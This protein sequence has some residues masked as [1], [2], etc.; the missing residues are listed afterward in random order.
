[1]WAMGTPIKAP[2]GED[3]RPIPRSLPYEERMTRP[4][5]LGDDVWWGYSVLWLLRPADAHALG[6]FWRGDR[7]VFAGWYGDLQ[8]PLV[9]TAIGFDTSDHVLDVDIAPDGTWVWKDE[10]EFAAAQRLGHFSPAEA[11]AI[12]AEGESV[13]AALERSAWPFNAR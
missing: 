6:A 8:A 13:I 9:R 3:G 12:R 7:R 2:I 11:A 10:D 1:M 4:W 5:R